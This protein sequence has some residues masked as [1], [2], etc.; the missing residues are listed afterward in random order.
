MDRGA[1]VGGKNGGVFGSMVGGRCTGAPCCTCRSWYTRNCGAWM[2]G[3]F[4]KRSSDQQSV[5]SGSCMHDYSGCGRRSSRTFLV[6]VIADSCFSK[7]LPSSVVFQHWN[8][9]NGSEEKT[10][11][12]RIWAF[13]IA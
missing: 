1:V 5:L 4:T 10:R 13:L 11:V 3:P 12:K 2:A 9:L 6:V 8:Y 7:S